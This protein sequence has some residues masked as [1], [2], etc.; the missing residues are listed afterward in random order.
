[1]NIQKEGICKLK[2]QVYYEDTDCGGVVYHSN[3]LNFCE[4]ARSELFFKKGLSPHNGNEFFVVKKI[5]ANYI[6]PAV[7][8]DVLDIHTTLVSKKNTSLVLEQNIYRNEEHLFN[9][10]VTVVFLNNMKPSRIPEELMVVFNE[11]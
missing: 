6:K 2:I 3:Y 5:E 4:R 7:F 1:L 9:M 8:G 11:N 10:Q